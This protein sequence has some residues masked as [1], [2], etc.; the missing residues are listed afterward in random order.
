M[1]VLVRVFRFGIV[2]VGQRWHPIHVKPP[3]NFLHIPLCFRWDQVLP[4]TWQ[5]MAVVL[6]LL[7]LCI[8]LHA[9]TCI[10]I[11]VASLEGYAD[12]WVRVLPPNPGDW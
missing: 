11:M 4:T 8:V 3:A 12:S 6:I 1:H 5:L 10:Y 7:V 2:S 9:E